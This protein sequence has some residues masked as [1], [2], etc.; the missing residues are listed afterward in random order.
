MQDIFGFWVMI[1]LVYIVSRFVNRHQNRINR[2]IERGIVDKHELKNN[3]IWDN[4]VIVEFAPPKWL[5]PIE[6]WYL[7]DMEIWESDIVCLLYRWAEMW[8]IS[9]SC[10]NN[11]VLKIIKNWS[12]LDKNVPKY[13]MKFWDM[14]FEQWN[15]VFF[16]NKF[17]YKDLWDFKNLV[18]EYCRDKCWITKKDVYFSVEDFFKTILPGKEPTKEIS[19][20]PYGRLLWFILWFLMMIIWVFILLR[21]VILY[22]AISLWNGLIFI[23]FFV[24]WMWVSFLFFWVLSET[25]DK[26]AVKLTKKWERLVAEIYWYKKFLESCEEN[27]L[28]EFMDKDPLYLDKVLPYAVAL[29]LENIISKKLPNGLSFEEWKLADILHFEKVI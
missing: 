9:L 8:I 7:Y 25:T 1:L 28:K 3:K 4:N 19:Y 29:G 22:G 10:E 13:E 26:H 15:I 2:E 5:S 20:I 24:G 27:Q 11:R 18:K 23:W 12:I 17:M 16:P 6:V 21:C 14:L